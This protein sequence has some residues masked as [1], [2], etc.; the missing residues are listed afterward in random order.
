[1]A[2]GV[3]FVPSV[4]FV[5]ACGNAAAVGEEPVGFDRVE[6]LV[7]HDCYICSCIMPENML[8][9]SSRESTGEELRGN[10][11]KIQQKSAAYAQAPGVCTGSFLPENRAKSIVMP[12]PKKKTTERD[13]S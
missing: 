13:V 2:K 5:A 12:P 6:L 9:Y 4:P 1:M 7:G 3:L 10:M 11:R 8:S